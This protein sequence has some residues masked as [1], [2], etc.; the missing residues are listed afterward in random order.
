[1]SFKSTEQDQDRFDQIVELKQD[2]F[3]YRPLCEA[4]AEEP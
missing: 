1:M 3:C 4:I 2:T